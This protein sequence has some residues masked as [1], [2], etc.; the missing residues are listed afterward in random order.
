MASPGPR[1]RRLLMLGVPLALFAVIA[2][3]LWFQ[4]TVV[5]Q[6]ALTDA[7][8]DAVVSARDLFAFSSQPE[9]FDPLNETSS[10]EELVDGSITLTAQ[11]E[12]TNPTLFVQSQVVL[13]PTETAAHAT[14]Q[15]I[16][17]GTFMSLAVESKSMTREERDDLFR[18]GDESKTQRLLIDGRPVGSF[19]VARKGTRVFTTVFTGVYFDDPEALAHLLTPKTEAMERLP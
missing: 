17:V 4:R 10:R 9:L 3:W 16:A 7:E 14:W 15:S 11:Y 8:R 19:V 18:W 2:G 6:R 13:E 12:S 1:T 5:S